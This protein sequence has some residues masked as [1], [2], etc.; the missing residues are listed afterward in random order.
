M[1]DLSQLEK[2]DYECAP[3][4]RKAMDYCREKGISQVVRV[5][6]DPRKDIGFNIMSLFHYGHDLRIVTCST[7]EEAERELQK[8]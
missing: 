3:S 2:M 8:H 4:I 5:I 7:L 1:T 6:P